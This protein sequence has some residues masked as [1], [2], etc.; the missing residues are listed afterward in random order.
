MVEPTNIE[1]DGGEVLE[2]GASTE[3]RFGTLEPPDNLVDTIP[4]A[5]AGEYS[6]TIAAVSQ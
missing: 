3:N 4:L 2:S 1:T 5:E 6:S